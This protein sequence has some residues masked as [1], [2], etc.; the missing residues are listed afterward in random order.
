M[1][2]LNVVLLLF[3]LAFFCEAY[4]EAFGIF[5]RSILPLYKETA[6]GWE[7]RL[8]CMRFSGKQ[9]LSGSQGVEDCVKVV[10]CSN[11]DYFLVDKACCFISGVSFHHYCV[12]RFAFFSA[13]DIRRRTVAKRDVILLLQGCHLCLQNLLG[14]FV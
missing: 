6:A 13:S 14:H 3:C 4:I 2:T 5:H 10:G 7:L 8:A 9:S 1:T 11:V 12:F